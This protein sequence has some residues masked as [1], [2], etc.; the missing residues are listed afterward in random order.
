MGGLQE[1]ENGLCPDLCKS[2]VEVAKDDAVLVDDSHDELEYAR[3]SVE[4]ESAVLSG[5][6]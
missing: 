5:W 2:R 6:S 4:P 3:S 1:V